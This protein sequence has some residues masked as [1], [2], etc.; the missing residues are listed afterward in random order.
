MVPGRGAA[1]SFQSGEVDSERPDKKQA[2]LVQAHASEGNSYRIRRFEDIFNTLDHDIKEDGDYGLLQNSFE[3]D[4]AVKQREEVCVAK[5]VGGAGIAKDLTFQAQVKLGRKAAADKGIIFAGLL[6]DIGESGAELFAMLRVVAKSFANY[7]II[8]LEN[9]SKDQFTRPGLEQECQSQDTWC[10][11]LEI[12]SMAGRNQHAGNILR[13]QHLTSL[14]QSLLSEVRK[15]VQYSDKK[16]D[17]VMMFDG[18]IF[19]EGSKGFHPSAVDAL[20]GFQMMPSGNSL[21]EEPLDVVCANQLAKA[22]SKPGRYRDV[23]A[24]RINEWDEQW[25]VVSKWQYD[26]LYFKG[27]QLVPV[28]ACFSGLSLYTMKAIGSQCNYVYQN[29]GVCEHVPFMHCLNQTG[30]GRVAIYPPL[31]VHSNDGG[32]PEDE[33]VKLS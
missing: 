8:A 13:V 23:F 28:R 12:P 4:M 17:Y 29:E 20:L 1:H 30:Y 22:R 25:N 11:L 10:F 21:A 32:L 14:R 27:N 18:D 26:E 2:M 6:R 19:D 7:H 5:E 15:L 31:V 3:Y 16:W 9:D 33:C 24:L